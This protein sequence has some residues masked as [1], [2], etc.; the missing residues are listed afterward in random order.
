M[1]GR[2]PTASSIDVRAIAQIIISLGIVP[3]LK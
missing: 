2:M 3:E 1:T